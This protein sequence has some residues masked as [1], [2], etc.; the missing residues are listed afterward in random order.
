MSR[1]IGAQYMVL[2][3]CGMAER[4]VRGCKKREVDVITC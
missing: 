3:K 4:V 1:K 2:K